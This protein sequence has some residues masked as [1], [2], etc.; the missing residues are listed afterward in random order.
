MHCTKCTVCRSR[1]FCLLYVRSTEYSHF[2]RRHKEYLVRL[3]SSYIDSGCQ[4]I[5][6]TRNA[7]PA[8]APALGPSYPPRRAF[9]LAAFVSFCLLTPCPQHG[10]RRIRGSHASWFPSALTCTATLAPPS[11]RLARIADLAKLRKCPVPASLLPRPFVP[12]AALFARSARLPRKA[13]GNE[14]AHSFGVGC[15]FPHPPGQASARLPGGFVA[16]SP[17]LHMHARC[18]DEASCSRGC[19]H[20]FVHAYS[21]C[22]RQ[23]GVASATGQED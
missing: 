12:A 21:A 9:S 6:P 15:K 22:V 14:R 11:P 23:H 19:S 3:F 4:S 20:Y 13:C 16:D 1:F 10:R 8:S 18:P 2:V 5:T 17:A 7:L